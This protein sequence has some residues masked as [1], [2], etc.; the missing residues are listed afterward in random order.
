MDRT[1]RLLAILH[2]LKASRW[3]RAADLADLFGVSTRT[4]Y[5]DM[6]VLGEAGVPLQAVPGKG[7]SLDEGYFLPPL[8]FSHDEAVML[9]LGADFLADHFEVH[10]RTAARSAAV[11]IET[12]LPGTLR[13]TTKTLRE[14]I[15]FVPVN[16]FDDPAE[17]AALSGLRRAL[18]AG[19]TVRF[20]YRARADDAAVA[21][22]VEPYGLLDREDGWTLVGRDR[23][24]GQVRSYRLA[25]V[26]N[27]EVTDE[28]YTRPGAYRSGYDG[29][30]PRT[31]EVL[32]RFDPPVADRVQEVPGFFVEDTERRPDGLY[33]TLRV[34]RAV[35]VLP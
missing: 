12:A 1:D 4:I 2:E 3:H 11:K 25:R 27:L 6:Q 14:G 20:D 29:E 19:R 28:A 17:R 13:E 10:Y 21:C 8:I 18:P 30:T 35:D 26:Q 16:A 23:A 7:Y 31:V 32:V 5:R 9:W 34:R 15:R 24:T 33:V 22:H